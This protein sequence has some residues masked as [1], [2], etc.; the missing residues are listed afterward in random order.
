MKKI[1]L[2][3]Y[4]AVLIFFIIK[5]N[6]TINNRYIEIYTTQNI[7]YVYPNLCKIE[8]ETGDLYQFNS[9]KQMQTFLSERTANDTY[10]Q[11]IKL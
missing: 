5:N 9:F 8:T 11:N 4:F 6:R 1:I 7:Y 2:I 10:P 3:L